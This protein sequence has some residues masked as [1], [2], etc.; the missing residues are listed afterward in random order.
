MKNFLFGKKI[1]NINMIRFTMTG[2]YPMNLS[3]TMQRMNFDHFNLLKQVYSSGIQINQ[4]SKTS[5]VSSDSPKNNIAF[6]TTSGV[7]RVLTVDLNKTI[8]DTI[9]LY[10]KIVNREH[11]FKQNNKIMF[12]YNAQVINIFDKRTIGEFFGPMSNPFIMVV[13]IQNLILSLKK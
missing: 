7:Q 6:K 5:L 3:N 9:L 11:L 2:A 13:D 8:S 1:P 4:G 12:L 10:L